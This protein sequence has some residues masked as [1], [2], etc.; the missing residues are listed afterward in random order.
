[1]YSAGEE[2]CCLGGALLAS[3]ARAGRMGGPRTCG[4]S[5]NGGVAPRAR[6]RSRT[7]AERGER[8]RARLTRHLVMVTSSHQH[9]ARGCRGSCARDE[10]VEMQ[11]RRV[12]VHAQSSGIH[13]VDGAW[14]VVSSIKCLRRSQRRFIARLRAGQAPGASEVHES[15]FRATRTAR[16]AMGPPLRLLH[17]RGTHETSSSAAPR[18]SSS[19]QRCCGRLPPR[20]LSE[21]RR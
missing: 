15:T 2:P 13:S 19:E 14:V 1:M 12:C 4:A 10:I 7:R 8:A 18:P 16:G 21:Q 20:V 9:A 3:H 17:L 6:R 5:C 11:Y